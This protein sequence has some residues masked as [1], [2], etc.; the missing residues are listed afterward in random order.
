[1]YIQAGSLTLNQSNILPLT[2]L[3]TLG[4]PGTSSSALSSIGGNLDL[5]NFN[6][7]V[8]GLADAAFNNAN[9]SVSSNDSYI[10]TLTL[11]NAAGTSNTFSG[12]IGTNGNA[13]I[14]L[15]MGG[16]G[17][18]VLAGTNPYKGGTAI[19][20]GTLVLANPN[21]GNNT[22][23]GPI[24]VI[25]NGSN[26]ASAGNGILQLAADN[27]IS[28]TTAM[29]L[30]GGTFSPN[31]HSE[32]LGTLTLAGTSGDAHS[33]INFG[34]T[35]GV[36][37]F[38]DSSGSLGSGILDIQGWN[39]QTNGG[40]NDQLIIGSGGSLSSAQ[41]SQ[42]QFINPN[43][44]GRNYTAIQRSNG[45]IVSGSA[46]SPTPEPDALLVLSLAFATAGVLIARRRNAPPQCA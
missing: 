20:G 41:L 29:T 3:I 35:P 2:S 45:E 40:G 11:A 22:V 1:T 8:G 44:A 39:G 31:G 13:G 5:N 12:S 27:Q 16:P 23:I 21:A 7:T 46:I 33:I 43:G 28:D 9:N 17:T 42:I 32:T 37:T 14:K 25:G 18:Q 36:L 10:R 15:I 30:A 19:N 6:Q 34:G 24:T 4:T 26:S 38:A